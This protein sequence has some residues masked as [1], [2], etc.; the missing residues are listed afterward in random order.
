MASL[1]VGLPEV[2]AKILDVDVERDSAR[3][4][5]LGARK[6]HE[7]ELTAVWLQ[8]YGDKFRV[9]HEGDETKVERKRVISEE[10]GI[11][12]C[13]EKGFVARYFEPTVD[14]FK[15]LGYAEL[16]RSVKDRTSYLLGLPEGFETEVVFDTYT[17]LEGMR[18]PTLSEIEVVRA[19]EELLLECAGNLPELVIRLRKTIVSVAEI[20]GYD[21]SDLKNWGPRQLAEHYRNLSGA[22]PNHPN[23]RGFCVT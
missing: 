23:L 7:R 8:G 19:P 21:E 16:S 17:N 18:I 4:L 2:E 14:F 5:S 12:A 15:G 10:N 6:L 22:L 3:L 9:R 13:D 1:T 20:L 11:K